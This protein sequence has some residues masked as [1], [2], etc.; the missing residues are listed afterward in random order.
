[1]P[2]GAAQ[3]SVALRPHGAYVRGMNRPL[4]P[5]ALILGLAGLI[6]FLGA[7]LAA[8]T[9]T[10]ESASRALLALSAYAAVILAFLGGVHWGFALTDGAAIRARIGL[11]VVP[12]LIG[13]IGLLL[14]FVGLEIVGLVVMVAGFIG[15]TIMEARATTR[16]LVP[17]GYMWLRWLLSTVVIVCLVSVC[18]IRTLGG[19]V[20]L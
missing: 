9:L 11:G 19:P 18:L 12:S 10:G 20:V 6:P 7:S 14:T 15:L 1:M 3:A 16:G 17:R 5:M 13:W 2:P 4:P 8:T